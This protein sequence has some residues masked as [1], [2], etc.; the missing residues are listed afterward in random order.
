MPRGRGRS[1]PSA[2]LST[3]SGCSSERSA[4]NSSDR[5]IRLLDIFEVEHADEQ[6][7]VARAVAHGADADD[8]IGARIEAIAELRHD[9]LVVCT[10]PDPAGA[11]AHARRLHHHP[12]KGATDV[13]DRHPIVAL[14]HDRH[15]ELRRVDG[16]P[17]G[18][19][20]GDVHEPGGGRTDRRPRQLALDDA[21]ELV[22]VG[23]GHP[24]GLERT[25]R[26]SCGEQL[27]RAE[28]VEPRR[29]PLRETDPE[30]GGHDVEQ[31]HARE[32]ASGDERDPHQP[33]GA[34]QPSQSPDEQQA[35]EDR[36][37]Q[38]VLKPAGELQPHLESDHIGCHPSPEPRRNPLEDG[39]LVRAQSP[40]VVDGRS[41]CKS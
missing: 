27:E 35:A 31:D 24:A 39:P 38:Q 25:A 32:H 33:R 8:V 34:E 20:R 14:G 9:A 5:S 41:F 11:Q 37:G 13:D 28:V 2:R 17:H 18:Q 1:E 12:L 7:D 19:R 6:R 29:S 10:G 21:E 23:V 36:H 4:K 16:R 15:E 22:A 3:S 40:H 30:L 26:V